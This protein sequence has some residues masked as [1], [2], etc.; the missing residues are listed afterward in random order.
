MQLISICY[1][2]PRK[3]NRTFRCLIFR[4]FIIIISSIID[5]NIANSCCSK[6]SFQNA[7]YKKCFTRHVI[8]N[9]HLSLLCIRAFLPMNHIFLTCITGTVYSVMETVTKG[10]IHVG[11]W[12]KVK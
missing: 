12:Q 6:S 4:I 9:I 10:S 5:V 3:R 2:H 7:L 8:S 1:M 11:L